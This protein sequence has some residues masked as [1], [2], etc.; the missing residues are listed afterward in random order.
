MRDPG[1]RLPLGDF[2][3]QM[4]V[5]RFSLKRAVELQL[6][7]YRHILTN[8]PRR[9]FADA[10]RSAYLALML[11]IANHNPLRKLRVK[12]RERDMLAAARSGLWPPT[13]T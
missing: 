3:R 2:G 4:V 9:N 12:H 10:T 8:P 1:Y 11:E 6:D 5:E 13:V 7:I